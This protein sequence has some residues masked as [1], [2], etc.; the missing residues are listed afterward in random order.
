MHRTVAD[1]SLR[2]PRWLLVT[3]ILL[4][5]SVF[6]NYIDRGNLATAAPLI[7][8]ELGLSA[9]QLGFLLTA[10]FITYMPMQF[11]VGWLADRFG[12]AHVLLAGFIVWS[13]AMA[14]TGL[15]HGFTTLVALRVL[16]GIG[17]SV[18]FP[19]SSIIIARCFPESRRGMANS[20]VM[21]GMACGPAFGIFFGGLL[22]AVY[23]WRAFFIGFGLV[24]LVWIIPWLAIAQSRLVEHR[25]EA[26]GIPPATRTILCERSLWGA[27]LGHFCANYVWYF[28]LSW[29]PYYL[30]HERHWSMTQMATIG[31]S[32]YLLMALTTMLTGWFSDRQIA[33]GASP[34]TVR[35]SL[36]GAGCG[37]AAVCIVGCAVTGTET[38]VLLLLLACAAFGLISPNIYAVAQSLAG[39]SAAGRWVGIQNGI[40]NIAG[41][42]APFLT[43]VLVDRTGN[44]LLA[45]LIA[46]AV[47]LLGAI[48]WIFGVGPVA[49]ID[50]ARR[51][52]PPASV[53]PT[54]AFT[55]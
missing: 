11:V 8:D 44:F 21:A 55:D 1:P 35:K 19:T 32:A 9:T 28:V 49:Q 2:M 7:K 34:T 16:L 26:G 18:F 30:V 52:R 29:I 22:I 36:L 51:H 47:C 54:I 33:A 24:S 43:G 40:G 20:V 12:A 5:L 6:I 27:S 4:A 23:G 25:A 14:F 15:A 39:A 31:G 38:S 13:L 37:L 10:F 3:L 45:F 53:D 17:E 42:V 50:W 41:L 46:A 48:A